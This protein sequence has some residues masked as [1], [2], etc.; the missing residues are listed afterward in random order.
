V[1][2]KAGHAGPAESQEVPQLKSLSVLEG[3]RI[4]PQA[5][6]SRGAATLLREQADAAIKTSR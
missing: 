6:V 5:I 4:A 3:M 2:G 1:S